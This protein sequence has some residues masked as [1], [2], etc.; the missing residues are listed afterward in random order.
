M[1]STNNEP[2]F[3][4]HSREDSVFSALID[5][6]DIYRV[7][8]GLQSEILT[9]HSRH[10]RRSFAE[11][12]T[13][14]YLAQCWQMCRVY[15]C[16]N[17]CLSTSTVFLVT[18]T[19]SCLL[20]GQEQGHR[21]PSDILQRQ[22]CYI[23]KTDYYVSWDMTYYFPLQQMWMEGKDRNFSVHKDIERTVNEP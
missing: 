4:T 19:W 3:T 8:R 22:R 7:F 16:S 6:T 5:R 1:F 12:T 11:A 23:N 18:F 2:P 13:D 15:G 21:A 14:R 9:G 20:W 10:S 17:G